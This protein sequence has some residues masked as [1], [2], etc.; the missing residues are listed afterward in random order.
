MSLL[1]KNSTGPRRVL[2]STPLNTFGMNQNGDGPLVQHQSDLTNALLDEWAKTLTDILQ[3][4]VEK[5]SQISGSCAKGG[6]TPY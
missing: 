4:L 6:P 3:N 5:P 1:W 2:A